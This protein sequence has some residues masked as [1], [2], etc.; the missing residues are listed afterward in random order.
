[1]NT[2]TPA[3]VQV[4]RFVKMRFLPMLFAHDYVRAE[5]NVFL[6]ASRFLHD[7]DGCEWTFVT[8]ENGGGFMQPEGDDWEF[9][10]P[11]NG[12]ALSLSAEA[13]GIVITGLVLNHRSWFYDRHDEPDLCEFYCQ[14]FRQLTDYAS[15]HPEYDTIFIA[16]N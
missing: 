5:H 14:R 11:D 10:N 13:A 15:S 7:Y 9:C 1:M 4:D 2:L 16:L 6:Y 3:A 12:R 8:L